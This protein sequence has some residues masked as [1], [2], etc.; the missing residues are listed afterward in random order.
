MAD[1]AI[2]RQVG[3]DFLQVFLHTTAGTYIKYALEVSEWMLPQKILRSEASND[4]F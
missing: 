1:P 2:A 4:A 3:A